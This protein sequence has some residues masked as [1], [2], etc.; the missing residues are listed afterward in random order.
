MLAPNQ[1]EAERLTLTAITTIDDAVKAALSLRGV[2]AEVFVKLGAAG[3]VADA[4]NG[5]WFA[6]GPQLHRGSAVGAGDAF[7]AAVLAAK[8]NGA[9]LEEA[10]HSAVAAGGAV[11][12]STGSDLLTRADYEDMLRLVEARRVNG[13]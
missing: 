12:Q 1:H 10:L 7:L 11:L 4:G 8:R 6:K 3:A 2:A 13:A 5:C 9:P